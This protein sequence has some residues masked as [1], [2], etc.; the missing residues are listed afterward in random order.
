M[1]ICLCHGCVYKLSIRCSCPLDPPPLD[2]PILLPFCC[3]IE[4]GKQWVLNLGS[5]FMGGTLHFTLC[6]AFPPFSCSTL[7]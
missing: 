3:V 1:T 5:P 4:H 2:H 7:A 6:T